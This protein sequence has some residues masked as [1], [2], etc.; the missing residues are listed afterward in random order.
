MKGPR[1]ALGLAAALCEGLCLTLGGCQNGA[2]ANT[3]IR[4]QDQWMMTHYK[5]QYIDEFVTRF[6][7]PDAVLLLQNRAP[8]RGREALQRK[9]QAD[10]AAIPERHIAVDIEH[11]EQS[12]DLAVEFSRERQTLA[13]NAG[14]S[15]Q[16]LAVTYLAV[17]KYAP[18]G[19]WRCIALAAIRNPQDDAA[20]SR[21]LPNVAQP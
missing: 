20:K 2:D 16:T 15:P 10:F 11:I 17:W 19:Q 13:A 6:F 21:P 1:I 3:A 5:S 7:A 9:F 8:I 4:E 12:G 14:E 18:G